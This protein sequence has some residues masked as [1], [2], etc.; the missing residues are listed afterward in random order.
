MGINDLCFTQNQGQLVTCSSDRSVKVWQVD[1]GGKTMDETKAYKLSAADSEGLK[2]NVEKQIL[3]L[4]NDGD[5]VI[6]VSCN[7]DINRWEL[8]GG[9]EPVE[10]IRGHMN[11]VNALAMWH[12]KF[13]ISGDTDGRV[14]VQDSLTGYVTRPEGAYKHKV[15]VTA[16]ACNDKFVYTSASDMTMLSYEITAQDDSKP[17]DYQSFMKSL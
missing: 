15:S 4:Q 2:E 12:Q 5:T 8:Q 7:S 14:L 3:A 16:V 11:S 1:V 17:G 6:A 10:T 9:E 13:I